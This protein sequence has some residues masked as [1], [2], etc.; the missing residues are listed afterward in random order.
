MSVERPSS[1]ATNSEKKRWL[2][3]RSVIINGITPKPEDEIEL[4]L[5][6][7]VFFPNGKR[8]TTMV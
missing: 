8:R 5:T 2:L 3:Q 1:V 6:S 7:L 4:P